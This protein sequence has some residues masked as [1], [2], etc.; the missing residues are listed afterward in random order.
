[1]RFSH[2]FLKTMQKN[3]EIS[4]LKMCHI[5]PRASSACFSGNYQFCLTIRKNNHQSTGFTQAE[6]FELTLLHLCTYL[7]CHKTSCTPPK[8]GT[9]YICISYQQLPLQPSSLPTMQKT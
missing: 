1:M 6:I 9:T 2:H 5:E 8:K 3:V 7:D 4:S